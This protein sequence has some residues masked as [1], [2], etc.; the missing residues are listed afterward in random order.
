MKPIS[1]LPT[2]CGVGGVLDEIFRYYGEGGRLGDRESILRWLKKIGETDPV[3][4]EGIMQRC[5][6]DPESRAYFRKL[7]YVPKLEIVKQ[8]TP[9][10]PAP[11]KITPE[12][13]CHRC[14]NRRLQVSAGPVSLHNWICESTKKSLG[15]NFNFLAGTGLPVKCK[16]RIQEMA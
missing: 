6:T 9:N 4:I 16:V 8:W 3:I 11:K 15:S 14:T 7:A 5:S 10:I 13:L 12:P 2:V 1:F